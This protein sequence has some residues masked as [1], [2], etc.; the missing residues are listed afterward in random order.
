LRSKHRTDQWARA[1]DSR[2]VMA[3]EH[4]AIGW[5]VIETIVMAIGRRRPRTIDAECPVGDE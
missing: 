5:N 1:C 4:V 3:E 2:E